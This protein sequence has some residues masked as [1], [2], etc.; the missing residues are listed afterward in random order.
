MG[1]KIL[2]I[3]LSNI[4]GRVDSIDPDIN[5]DEAFADPRLRKVLTL[6]LKKLQNQIID[7]QNQVNQTNKK[8]RTASQIWEWLKLHLKE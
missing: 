2:T 5:L 3:N 6:A 1:K 4:P 8:H 7:L